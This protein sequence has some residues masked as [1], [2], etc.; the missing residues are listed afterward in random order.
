MRSS[1]QPACLPHAQPAQYRCIP[2]GPS[3]CPNTGPQ[4]QA[5][6]RSVRRLTSFQTLSAAYVKAFQI[7]TH[8]QNHRKLR[9]A[10]FQLTVRHAGCP[11]TFP[12]GA[13]FISAHLL[14]GR[15]RLCA[16]LSVSGW[17][18]RGRGLL[19]WRCRATQV[20]LITCA[21]QSCG[22]LLSSQINVLSAAPGC[23]KGHLA[24]TRRAAPQDLSLCITDQSLASCLTDGGACCGLPAGDSSTACASSSVAACQALVEA[25]LLS[26]GTCSCT[27][28]QSLCVTDARPA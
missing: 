24:S 15:T 14:C 19:V 16:H 25:P 2:A 27:L 7:R 13:Q 8:L 4:R 11:R 26:V 1:A 5:P 22:Q 3:G 23:I 9:Y 12:Y 18:Y 28:P 17:C 6:S 21:A 10:F 20:I